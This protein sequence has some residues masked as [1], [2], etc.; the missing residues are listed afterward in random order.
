MPDLHQFI[1]FPISQ[2]KLAEYNPRTIDEDNE[3]ALMR[4]LA[5]DPDFLYDNPIVVNTHAGREGV[6][7][8]GNQRVKA[9]LALGWTEVPVLL[10]DVDELNEKRRNIQ[11]NHHNGQFDDTLLRGVLIDIHQSNFD[12]ATLGFTAAELSDLMSF[13]S[14]NLGATDD[15]D[16]NGTAGAK[17]KEHTCPNCGHVFTD[18]AKT[19]A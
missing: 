4:S 14:L 18:P 13:D 6:V 15:P 2:L 5:A 10:S 8:I 12:M 17:Q 3:K 19:D 7:Y 16:Y 1:Q 11:A 9:A